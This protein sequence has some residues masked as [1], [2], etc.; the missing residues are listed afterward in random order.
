MAKETYLAG[1]LVGCG[2]LQ[3]RFC[4]QPDRFEQFLRQLAWSRRVLQRSDRS[5][6][7]GCSVAED[8][9]VIIGQTWRSEHRWPVPA[10]LP[11]RGAKGDGALDAA[12]QC[13]DDRRA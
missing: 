9:P 13:P 7:L 10:S 6:R 1:A 5:D 12:P 2:R 4:L 3:G 11:G 8:E